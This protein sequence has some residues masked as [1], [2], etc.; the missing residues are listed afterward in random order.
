MQKIVFS[1]DELPAHLDNQA[2]FKL[3]NEIY[4]ERYG[5]AQISR[6]DKPFSSR[7]MFGQVGEFGLVQSSGTIQRYARNARQVSADPRDDFLIGFS[8]CQSRM[9]VTQRGREVPLVPGGMAIYTNAE[10]SECFCEGD[11]A[12]SGLSVPRARLGELVADAD[13]RIGRPLDPAR[14]AIRHLGRYVDFLLT[15]DE[16]AEQPPLAKKICNILLDLTV[17]ALGAGGDAAE[18]A[19]GRGLRAARTREILAEIGARFSDPAFSARVVALKLGLSPRYV[20][21]LVQE[22]GSSF[23]ERMLELRLQ[24]A[25]AMLADSRNDRM[26]V[27]DIALNC[28]F[29]EVSY[30][31]RCFRRRFGCSP[32]QYRAGNGEDEQA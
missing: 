6:L 19:R 14:P 18:I 28:G 13:G 21:E 27:G 8:R 11:N 17:L 25:R 32:M 9:L 4:I 20:Q 5:D 23:T 3:W 31:N 26:R 16:V 7:S 2:R 10:P 24:R 30:F 22:T 1:S 12:W 15:S 29:N